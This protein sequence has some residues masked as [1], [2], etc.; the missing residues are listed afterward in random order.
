MRNIGTHFT[1]PKTHHSAKP[2]V[3][4][5][6]LSERHIRSTSMSLLES[7]GRVGLCGEMGLRRLLRRIADDEVHADFGNRQKPPLVLSLFSHRTGI[8][9]LSRPDL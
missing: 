2:D 7:G 9:L 1:A 6:W 4:I 8:C 5:K 3:S